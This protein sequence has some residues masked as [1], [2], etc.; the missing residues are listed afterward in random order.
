MN[1][2]PFQHSG[3][4][5]PADQIPTIEGERIAFNTEA[6]ATIHG[7]VY[8]RTLY[9]TPELIKASGS[10]PLYVIDTTSIKI[11]E[12][13]VVTEFG[14]ER[15]KVECPELFTTNNV[16]SFDY[17]CEG[18]SQDYSTLHIVGTHSQGIIT[19][20]LGENN[21]L[22]VVGVRYTGYFYIPS[23]V[24]GRKMKPIG[25][26]MAAEML[27]ATEIID[28]FIKKPKCTI[29][30][31]SVLEIMDDLTYTFHHFAGTN[32]T[33]CVAQDANGFV[34]GHGTSVCALTTEFDAQIGKDYA[35]T[36]CK[37]KAE[38]AIW[39]F[40]GFNHYHNSKKT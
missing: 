38:A 8:L 31:E 23:D 29:S 27:E 22:N 15:V 12:V 6:F 19:H 14:V 9:E 26:D 33:V 24:Y 32:F 7:L 3:T 34:Y 1:N 18:L 28:E 10:N 13:K 4:D 2:Q 25:K 5:L 30:A 40:L 20:S 37:E 11:A 36:D 16:E 21:K 39:G 35:L 17:K